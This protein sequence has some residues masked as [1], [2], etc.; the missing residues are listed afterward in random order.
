M[1][2]HI[3][4]TGLFKLDGGAMHG[5]I[6]KSMWQKQNPADDNNMS[7]W[8]MRCL[9]V[10]DGDRRILIDCGMGNKQSEKFF[11]YYYPTGHVLMQSLKEKGFE[12]DDITDVFL[13]HL[14]FDHCGGAVIKENDELKLQFPKAKYW[15]NKT[16]WQ[17]A[18]NPNPR[19][20]ASFLIENLAPIEASGQLHFIEEKDGV[21]FTENIS[22]RFA[23]GHTEKMMM[24]LIDCNGKKIFYAA[25]LIPSKAHISIPWVMAYDMQPLL[26]LKEKELILEEASQENWLLFF[27]HDLHNACCELI[28]TERGIRGG[29]N[30]DIETL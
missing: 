10:E 23:S 2:L 3:I 15:S 9:L 7:T 1:K 17:L 16:H 14:H 28:A 26:T 6:P 21:Q 18:L 22:I 30:I 19:E 8:A 12:S 20:K 4:D 13:T 25:D 24:P 29:E 27:E 5:V 11:S